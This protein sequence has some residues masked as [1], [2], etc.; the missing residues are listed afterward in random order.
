MGALLLGVG[1]PRIL[2]RR[3]AGRPSGRDVTGRADRQARHTARTA[4][5]A[6]LALL[7]PLSLLVG[8]DWATRLAAASAGAA[9]VVGAAALYGS[10]LHAR[11]RH[12]RRWLADPPGPPR[13][14]PPE[15][16]AERWLTGRRVVLAVVGGLVLGLLTGLVL[17]LTGGS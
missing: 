12:A 3:A 5:I 1:V 11:V 10:W 15:T 13:D 14:A 2:P 16:R 7:G 17:G 8:G 4:N 6:W 9:L